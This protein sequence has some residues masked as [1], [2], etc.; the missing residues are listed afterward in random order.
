MTPAK[1]HA[2]AN[3]NQDVESACKISDLISVAGEGSS[4]HWSLACALHFPGFVNITSSQERRKITCII[5]EAM[6]LRKKEEEG[7]Q[8]RIKKQS[9]N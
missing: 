9:R 8:I 3:V 2:S 1:V 5:H 6:H 7:V 4:S